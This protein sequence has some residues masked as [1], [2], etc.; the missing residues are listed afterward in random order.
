MEKRRIVIPVVFLL[1]IALLLEVFSVAKD[2][3]EETPTLHLL[4]M[5]VVCEEMPEDKKLHNLYIT[6]ERL[7][8]Y[9]DYFTNSDYQIVSLE[10]AYRIFKGEEEAKKSDLLVF[11]FDDGYE[12]NYLLGYPVLQKYGVK[13]NINVVA[14]VIEDEVPLWGTR[15]LRWE[16]IK[17]MQDSGLIE[18]G[19]HTYNSHEYTTDER[20]KSVPLLKAKLAGET[21]EMRKNRIFDDLM[22]ADQ[23]ISENLGVKTK[24][25]AYPYGVPPMDLL[26]EIVEKLEYPIGM[27]VTQGV[28]RNLEDFPML[29]RFT[30]S[31]NESAEQ[32]DRRMKRYKGMDFLDNFIIR[33][34]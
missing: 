16:Q 23:L 12:D 26:K 19:S 2:Q 22:K 30:V 32:L 3:Y 25:M 33:K 13:A 34:N 14:K 8:E 18:I 24:I 4:M 7:A 29:N 10:E 1:L 21:D 6:T 27:L 9:C 11:T 31:G 5:H 17:E 28:N 15:Y 20:G